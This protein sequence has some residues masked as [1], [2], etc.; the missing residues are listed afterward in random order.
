MV[1]IVVHAK[2]VVVH[3]G[4]LRLRTNADIADIRAHLTSS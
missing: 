3:G 2:H 4:D 1:N